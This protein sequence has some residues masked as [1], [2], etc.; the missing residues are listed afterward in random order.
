MPTSPETPTPVAQRLRLVAVVTAVWI[1]LGVFLGTQSHVN[2]VAA[3]HPVPLVKAV[4]MAVQRYLLYALLTFP[5]L[6][7]CRRVPFT[8]GRRTR[9]LAKHLLGFAGFAAAYTTLRTLTGSVREAET[10]RPLPPSLATAGDL[11]RSSLFEQFWMYASIVGVIL[12][13]EHL[14]EV[15]VRERRELQL[16]Q[17]VAEYRLQVLRLQLQPH[18]L[19]NAMNGIATL[20]QRDVPTARAMLLRLSDL[21]RLALHGSEENTIALREEIEFVRAYL[22]L[23]QMRF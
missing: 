17:R 22:D 5:V 2:T 12:A 20:M 21:L 16:K 9:W 1:L 23:E 8:A 4:L 19:F 3:G 7:L 18:F 14:R 15:A 13:V 6:W 10:L 11:L